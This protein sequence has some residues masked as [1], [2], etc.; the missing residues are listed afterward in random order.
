VSS[1]L[2]PAAAALRLGHLRPDDHVD[3]AGLVFQRHE[4]HALGRLGPLAV[5]DQA[6][7]AR[8]PAVG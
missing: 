3:G 7:G 5:R 1:V 2:P 6:A 4:D 8:Q